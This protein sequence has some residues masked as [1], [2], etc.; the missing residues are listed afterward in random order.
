MI[1]ANVTNLCPSPSIDIRD[2]KAIIK[3]DI[4]ARKKFIRSNNRRDS[5]SY[6]AMACS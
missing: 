4:V 3:K 6:A 5:R 1:T 2:T